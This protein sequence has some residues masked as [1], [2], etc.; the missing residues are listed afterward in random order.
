MVVIVLPNWYGK[1]QEE[2]RRLV[3]K[4]ANEQNIKF[5]FVSDSKS[6]NSSIDSI[7][8]SLVFLQENTYPEFTVE[9]LKNFKEMEKLNKRRSK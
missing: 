9:E 8:N 7:C 3:H 6:I 4:I 5:Q 2:I 1:A